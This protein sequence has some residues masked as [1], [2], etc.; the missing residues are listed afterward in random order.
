[1]NLVPC[2]EKETAPRSVFPR[3]P[4]RPHSGATLSCRAVCIEH[5]NAVVGDA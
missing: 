1:M 4:A 2:A 5:E 3:I